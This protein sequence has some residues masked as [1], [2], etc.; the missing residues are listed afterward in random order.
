MNC[1]NKILIFLGLKQKN[2]TIRVRE[3]IKRGLSINI[4]RNIIKE[5]VLNKISQPR[6]I[7]RGLYKNYNNNKLSPKV[8]HNQFQDEVKIN[9]Y[10]MEEIIPNYWSCF[11]NLV[12]KWWYSTLILGILI[13]QPIYNFVHFELNILPSLLLQISISIQYILLINYF[14]YSHYEKYVK[15][16]KISYL[17]LFLSI[18]S[19]VYNSINLFIF[20]NDVEISNFKNQ[21]L[22]CKIFM[23]VTF[24]FIWFFSKM[25]LFL[26]TSVF[27][28]VLC[29]HTQEL[30]HYSEEITTDQ[31]FEEGNL[32]IFKISNSLTKI[33]HTLELSVQLFSNLF[34][35]STIMFALSW[36]TLFYFINHDIKYNIPW[37]SLII[38]TINH[39]IFIF[40]ISNFSNSKKNLLKYIK[41]PTFLFKHFSRYTY[42]EINKK[43]KDINMIMINLQEENSASIEWISLYLVLNEKWLE[44][45]VLG[46]SFE[47]FDFFKKVIAVVIFGFSFWNFVQ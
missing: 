39:C 27:T 37:E 45:S 43:F 23:Y 32:N 2:H 33:R 21:S 10:E 9:I 46:I 5:P 30:K 47:N 20:E 25:I 24:P 19:V 4:D 36:S 22:F 41:G 28:S 40:N 16:D 1:F 34:S 29:E 44:F 17:I 11:K 15:N 26:H 14:S 6:N 8:K 38:Y 7:T 3:K 13:T 42:E 18:I 35:F 12:N 31:L